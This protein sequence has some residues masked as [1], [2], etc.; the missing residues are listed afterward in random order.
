VR[1]LFDLTGF[2]QV[3]ALHASIEE[4]RAAFEHGPA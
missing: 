4:A 1:E 2:V 3:F